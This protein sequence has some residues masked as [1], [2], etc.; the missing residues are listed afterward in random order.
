MESM[1]HQERPAVC[2]AFTHMVEEI[3]T[4]GTLEGCYRM[5][6]ATHLICRL[7]R[8]GMEDR[9]SMESRLGLGPQDE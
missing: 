4:Q 2:R 9:G 5:F 1:Y 3:A 8:I 6:D 7:E